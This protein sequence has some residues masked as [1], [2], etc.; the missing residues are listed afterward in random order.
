MEIKLSKEFEYEGKTYKT[1]NLDMDKLTG[2]DILAVESEAVAMAGGPV[3]DF[4]KTYQAVLAAK[5]AG[6]APDMI[7]A[8]PAKDFLT[9]TLEASAFLL[10]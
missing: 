9:V 4:S 1:L 7:I 10:A 8:L 6:V 3:T 5:A 2:K